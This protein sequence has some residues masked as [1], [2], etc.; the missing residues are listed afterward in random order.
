MSANHAAVLPSAVEL[1]NPGT[2]E[3]AVSQP[4]E[5]SRVATAT[6][7]AAERLRATGGGRVEVQVQLEDGQS[8]TL[9]LQVTENQV[10]PHFVTES[11]SLRQ[12]LE[13]GWSRF[14]HRAAER[15]LQIAAPVFESGQSQSGMDF[16]QPRDGRDSRGDRQAPQNR[17]EASPAA[18]WPF[19]PRR[20]SGDSRQPPSRVAAAAANAERVQLYA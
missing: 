19:P 7:E 11:E 20:A 15:G 2:V 8:L 5:I 13:Q 14:T 18:A 1:A 12:A 4:S 10:Q 16:N 17:E 9:R 3:R 6:L